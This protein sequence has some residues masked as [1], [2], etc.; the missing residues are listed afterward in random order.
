MFKYFREP[1][2]KE[3]S[4]LFPLLSSP[5]L[6]ANTLLFIFSF[7]FPLAIV[8]EYSNLP[9]FFYILS[10]SRFILWIEA[11]GCCPLGAKERAEK[12]AL[13]VGLDRSLPVSRDATFLDEALGRSSRRASFL[14]LCL[15]AS[16]SPLLGPNP[17]LRREAGVA[18]SHSVASSSGP[19]QLR[20]Y[21]NRSIGFRINGNRY[22]SI[23]TIDLLYHRFDDLLRLV[24]LDSRCVD[25]GFL[26]I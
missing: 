22:V 11:I 18:L 2:Y 1:A 4:S 19:I 13:F 5:L 25:C 7:F 9:I 26:R 12:H 24:R 21:R 23:L 3:S 17:Y 6:F 10:S 8:L 20:P 16:R 15:S 14:S